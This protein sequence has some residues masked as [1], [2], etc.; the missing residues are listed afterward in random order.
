MAADRARTEAGLKQSVAALFRS[1]FR[2]IDAMEHGRVGGHA[3]HADHVNGGQQATRG[4]GA[5]DYLGSELES[6]SELGFDMVDSSDLSVITGW[7]LWLLLLLLLLL[8]LMMMMMIMMMTMM[9]M[10]EVMEIGIDCPCVLRISGE[11][12]AN[13]L[14][15]SVCLRISACRILATPIACSIFSRNIKCSRV[16]RVIGRRG[17]GGIGPQVLQQVRVR[18]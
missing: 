18:M 8:L 14:S 17:R 1:K 7:L 10:M 3:G 13:V 5:V 6:E 11:S 12:T 9:M 16:R 2:P 4:V 15:F